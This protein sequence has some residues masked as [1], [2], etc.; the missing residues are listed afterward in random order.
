M[1][2]FKGKLL[3]IE[4]NNKEIVLGEL[5]PAK[6]LKESDLME[7]KEIH[8]TFEGFVDKFEDCSIN[9]DLEG[10]E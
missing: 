8:I 4:K 7:G 2:K 10:G 3:K 9:T 6:T 1:S 5:K